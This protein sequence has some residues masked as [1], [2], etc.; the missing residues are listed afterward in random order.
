MF[1]HLV[2]LDVTT[3]KMG[4]RIRIT[5]I[6]VKDTGIYAKGIPYL[7]R[8]VKQCEKVF[9]VQG[10]LEQI[11]QLVK[12]I[13]K[14]MA[15]EKID[16]FDAIKVEQM[17]FA[18]MN[19]DQIDQFL[20][21]ILNQSLKLHNRFMKENINNFL[22]TIIESRSIL[23]RILLVKKHLQ[24]IESVLEVRLLPSAGPRRPPAAPRALAPR[25]PAPRTL[26]PRAHPTPAPRARREIQSPTLPCEPAKQ[27]KSL[28]VH[29]PSLA[30]FGC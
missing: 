21:T 20:F 6:E 28:L 7:D 23:N 16:L 8:E 14:G 29:Q 25:A 18:D 30:F 12:N 17:N 27:K 11:S 4:N 22:Q 24:N 1:G 9:N 26:A 13:R 10:E 15:F 19:N 3:K 5:E 2:N